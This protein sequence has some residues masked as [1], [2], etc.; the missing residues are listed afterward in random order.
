MCGGHLVQMSSL[1]RANFTSGIVILGLST[2]SSMWTEVS[3]HW[4]WL[5]CSATLVWK[6]LILYLVTDQN[7]HCTCC[8]QNNDSSGPV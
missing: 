4:H 8:I 2:H 3:H 7:H 5:Q 6:T 1:D